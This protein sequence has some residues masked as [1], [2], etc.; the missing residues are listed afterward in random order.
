MCEYRLCARHAG[1]G[2]VPRSAAR[3]TQKTQGAVPAVPHVA[4]RTRA[5]VDVEGHVQGGRVA[6]WCGGGEEVALFARSSSGGKIEGGGGRERE[7]EDRGGGGAAGARSE[8][9]VN[10]P[11]CL[12]QGVWV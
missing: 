12:V 7:E 1:G 8:C 11:A 9:R 4:C 6:A 5:E 10:V 3:T 2:C